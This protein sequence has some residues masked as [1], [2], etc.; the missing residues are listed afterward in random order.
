MG[1]FV[2]SK[3]SYLSSLFTIQF[4]VERWTIKDFDN[5]NLRIKISD[6]ELRD[7]KLYI[8]TVVDRWIYNNPYTQYIAEAPRRYGITHTKEFLRREFDVAYKTFKAFA[9]HEKN[10]GISFRGIKQI[11]TAQALDKYLFSS[12]NSNIGVKTA[13]AYLK[14]L[15]DFK[16]DT[17][18]TNEIAIYEDAVMSIKEYVRDRHLG[19]QDKYAIGATKYNPIFNEHWY[20]STLIIV[21]LL[22]FAGRNPFTFIPLS[23]ELFDGDVNTG[24]YQPH[25][26]DAANKQLLQFIGIM[27]FDPVW[28]GRFNYISRTSKG[29]VLQERLRD[30]MIELMGKKTSITENDIRTVFGDLTIFGT[31]VSDMWINNIDFNTL[32]AEWN[33]DRQ[34]IQQ[35]K[36][37]QFLRGRFSLSDGSNPVLERYWFQAKETIDSFLLLMDDYDFSYLFTDADTDL[38]KRYF[39]I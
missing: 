25:H 10:P 17:K 21:D 15:E 28:H 1:I 30:G 20:K 27:I 8:D 32:L 6:S 2:N 16:K 14:I 9:V 26:L 18:D 39:K 33:D 31:K 23:S 11:A 36:F 19:F 38:L 29:I 5:D 34:L 13:K 7:L 24:L 22:R 12:P 4:N 35:G 37:L 3:A